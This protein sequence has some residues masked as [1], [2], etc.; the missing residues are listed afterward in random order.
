ML[1]VAMIGALVCLCWQQRP[2]KVLIYKCISFLFFF[3]QI[4]HVITLIKTC[5]G[6]SW[7]CKIKCHIHCSAC[8]KYTLRRGRLCHS[9]VQAL[10][11]WKS[12][13][14]LRLWSM[15]DSKKTSNVELKQFQYS[16][17]HKMFINISMSGFYCKIHKKFL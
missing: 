9:D 8:N 5:C 13:S 2:W 17:L 4:K 1:H 15:V 7:Y 14:L 3:V 11:A 12:K 16:G 10:W 6:F